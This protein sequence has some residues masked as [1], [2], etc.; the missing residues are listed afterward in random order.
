MGLLSDSHA[1]NARRKTQ[2]LLGS[3]NNQHFE[4]TSMSLIT[5]RQCVCFAL[6]WCKGRR[7]FKKGKEGKTFLF[8]VFELNCG[9]TEDQK[10]KISAEGGQN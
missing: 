6:T 4:S 2:G 1:Q 3:G 10:I 8:N 9:G 5:L 7:N